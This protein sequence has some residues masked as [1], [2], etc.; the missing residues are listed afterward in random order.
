MLKY[1]EIVQRQISCC[2]GSIFLLQGQ[3]LDKSFFKIKEFVIIFLGF[4]TSYS[5]F[6]ETWPPIVERII[7]HSISLKM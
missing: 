6:R 4:L 3:K 5:L 7:T 2:L 1:W